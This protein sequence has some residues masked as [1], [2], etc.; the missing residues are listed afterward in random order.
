MG[1]ALL[2]YPAL[3]PTL[4]DAAVKVVTAVVVETPPGTGSE[5]V[6]TLAETFVPSWLATWTTPVPRLKVAVDNPVRSSV[7]VFPT[8][9][10]A[11]PICKVAAAPLMTNAPPPVRASEVV[12][13]ETGT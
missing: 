4:K 8:E 7:A 3:S 5:S 2:L 10:V 9:P 1:L 13:V 12:A 11:P 6:A